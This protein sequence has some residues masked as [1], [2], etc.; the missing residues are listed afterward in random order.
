M[1]RAYNTPV[2][3]ITLDHA[4]LLQ[5]YPKPRLPFFRVHQCHDGRDQRHRFGGDRPRAASG[6]GLVDL[7][8][9]LHPQHRWPRPDAED[10]SDMRF[11]AARW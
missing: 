11:S 10:A 7:P 9:Q 5:A 1:T 2:T 4:F 6:L 3:P 8:G